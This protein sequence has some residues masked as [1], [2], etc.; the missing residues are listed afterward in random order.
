[1]QAEMSPQIDPGDVIE[2]PTNPT[3]A[4]GGNSDG[5]HG[6]GGGGG[7]SKI[8]LPSTT[9]EIPAVDQAKAALEKAKKSLTIT[10][11]VN[12][13]SAIQALSNEEK[14]EEFTKELNALKQELK[15]KE[16]PTKNEIRT[17]VPVGISLEVAMKSA[18]YKYIDESSI[19]DNVFIF[20]S[21]GELLRDVRIQVI[22]NRIFIEPPLNGRFPSKETYTIIIDTAVKGKASLDTAESFE[23]T[24]PLMLEFSTR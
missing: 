1:M 22:F 23:L 6:H 21:K 24:N 16:L 19:R 20:D 8:T 14:R 10:D 18:N 4:P 13:K 17:V 11:F 5:G 12:A 9:E 2:L 7:S 15:I 3:P